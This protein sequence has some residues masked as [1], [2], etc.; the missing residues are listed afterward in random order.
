VIG[1]K[2]TAATAQM[3]GNITFALP[4]ILIT[5][6]L[7]LTSPDVPQSRLIGLDPLFRQ[8]PRTLPS[9]LDLPQTSI[10]ELGLHLL[11]G[12]VTSVNLVAA[13]LGMLINPSLNR[14]RRSTDRI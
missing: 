11:N 14:D 4:T 10:E 6:I 8:L 12:S 13:Y 1:G 7:A 2:F 5:S 9:S 3:F